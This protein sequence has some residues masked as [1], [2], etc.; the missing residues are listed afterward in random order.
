MPQGCLTLV[1]L[2]Q[3]VG[4]D[5]LISFLYECLILVG[6]VYQLSVSVHT[7]QE[8]YRIISCASQRQ[9]FVPTNK[10]FLLSEQCDPLIR[11]NSM[12]NLL[13]WN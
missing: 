11:K 13:K 4:L 8:L 7:M 2:S 10:F 12:I 1:K 5:S 6:K 9:C 3:L